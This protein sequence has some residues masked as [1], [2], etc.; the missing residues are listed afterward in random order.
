[1]F[2][3]KFRTLVFLFRTGRTQPI[4][5]LFFTISFIKTMGKQIKQTMED[6]GRHFRPDVDTGHNWQWRLASVHFLLKVGQFYNI[7]SLQ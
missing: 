4:L 3:R 5:N 1:M 2:E 7:A 6:L